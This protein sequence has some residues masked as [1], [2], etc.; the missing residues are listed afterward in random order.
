MSKLLE[1]A[2]WICICCILTLTKLKYFMSWS[3]TIKLQCLRGNL[4]SGEQD[5]AT[6]EF[7]ERFWPYISV[8]RKCWP[9]DEFFMTVM[10]LR[11]CSFFIDLSQHFGIYLVVFALHFFIHGYGGKLWL[12]V[13]SVVKSRVV[14]P[15]QKYKTRN[16]Q[17]LIRK[18]L[19]R[20]IHWN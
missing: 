13:I 8:Y 20:E 1:E 16:F 15:Q 19:L 11:L 7:L 4:L 17:N 12:K 2:I 3:Y 18:R 6:K 9:K 10:K 14:Q 5:I